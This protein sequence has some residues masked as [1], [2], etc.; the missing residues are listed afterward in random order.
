MNPVCLYSLMAYYTVLTMLLQLHVH[1]LYVVIHQHG[2]HLSRN[3]GQSRI[4]CPCSGPRRPFFSSIA[5]PGSRLESQTMSLLST[6]GD[7]TKAYHKQNYW[8]Q[9]ASGSQLLVIQSV[10][11]NN[12]IAGRAQPTMVWEEFKMLVGM[13]EIICQKLCWKNW[14]LCIRLTKNAL[15]PAQVMESI[16][17]DLYFHLQEVDVFRI[18]ILHEVAV[19]NIM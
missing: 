4:S 2:L 18:V 6:L 19:R 14:S 11:T 3:L 12:V 5:C 17:F 1:I 10:T 15:L 13:V 9:L 7:Q 16:S 8:L